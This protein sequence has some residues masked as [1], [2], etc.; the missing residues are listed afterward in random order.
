MEELRQFLNP[1]LLPA[2]WQ[3]LWLPPRAVGAPGA[4]DSPD[5]AVANKVTMLFGRAAPRDYLDVEAALASGRYS[6]GRLLQ[7]ASER[8]A[9]FDPRY[10]AQALR[11]VDCWPDRECEASTAAR[12]R[13]CADGCAPGLPRSSMNGS[14]RDAP[15]GRVGLSSN[16][17]GLPSRLRR[18][19]PEQDRR[20]CTVHHGVARVNPLRML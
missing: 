20:L 15:V 14:K 3:R 19:A 9:G 13:T 2:L 6:G 7:L 4:A 16:W 1:V 17:R 11:A 5:D 12:W 18:R 8:D 10:F